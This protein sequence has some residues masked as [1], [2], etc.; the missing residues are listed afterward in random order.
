MILY[1]ATP[2][3]VVGLILRRGLMPPTR[4]RK[5]SVSEQDF[6][7]SLGKV[8]LSADP[9]S[10]EWWARHASEALGG[11]YAI[12]KVMLPAGFPLYLDP[13]SPLNFG[14]DNELIQKVDYYTTQ[15]IPP[16][17][18]HYVGEVEY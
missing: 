3:R 5:V 17:Y 9:D 6:P 18:I 2:R 10:A 7:E 15:A 1:H 11:K 14:P 8:F 12:L 13:N 4:R 16:K